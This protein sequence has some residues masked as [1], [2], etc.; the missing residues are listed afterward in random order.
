MAIF[1]GM[2]KSQFQD[3][4]I[5]IYQLK[6]QKYSLEYKVEDAFFAEIEGSLVDKGNLAVTVELVKS[7]TSMVLD[8]DI[9][10]T[11]E[12]TCDKSLEVFD[13]QIS[14]KE[15]IIYKFGEQDEELS[16]NLFVIKADTQG[17]NL[18][19]VIYELIA[20]NVP[21]KKLHPRFRDE[22][23]NLENGEVVFSSESESESEENKEENI[24]PR[25]SELLKL[26][27]N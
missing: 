18:A 8:F 4:E 6:N 14:T 13:E 24:D 22:D 2:Q 11:V 15:K 26:R 23:D 25:W 10:G 12:L 17:I 16:E 9:K 20:V 7:E 3:F 5:N 1:Q 19:M 27:K 21:Y